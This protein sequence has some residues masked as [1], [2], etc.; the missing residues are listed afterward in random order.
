MKYKNK[1]LLLAVAVSA[2]CSHSIFAQ[3]GKQT[4][5][6]GSVI[7]FEPNSSG[8]L[9]DAAGIRSGLSE[10]G[11][12]FGLVY[13]SESATN[14]AGGYNHDNHLAYV[15]QVVFIFEQDLERYTGIPDAK[16]E[17]LITNRNHDNNLTTQRVQ[18]SRAYFN[19]LNQEVW[20]G[21]SITRLGYLSFSRSFDDRRL[22]WRVGQ[23]N[24]QQTFDQIA[25][26]D[27]QT[28]SLCGGKSS[29]ARS[30]DTW[31]IHTWG[32][33]FAY[34]VTPE[35]TL[36]TGVLE[37][38][39]LST[40]RGRTWSFSTH[41]SKGVLIPVEA[42]YKTQVNGLPGLYN[43]GVMYNNADQYEL[44]TAP[45]DET[46][47]HNN[48]WFMWAGFNQQITRSHDALNRGMSLA[49]GFALGDQ[50]TDPF[51]VAASLS[52]RY[53]GLFDALPNDWIGLGV[54]YLDMSKYQ[55]RAQRLQN[56]LNGISDYSDPGYTPVVGH[57]IQLDLYYR[58]RPVPW[59]DIQPD[60]QY[61]IHPGAIKETQDAVVVGLKTAVRF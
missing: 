26:C 38:N 10:K 6:D 55:A 37:K 2:L 46:R 34:D 61:W 52:A 39:N 49:G 30:W 24:Y 41:G 18:D 27:F 16:I 11:F 4:T 58:F 33:T 17:G 25:P 5:W 32:T 43:L 8:M 57:S 28:L 13:T 60:I 20:G 51:H 7:G 1:A 47:S 12:N 35:L 9:G 45:G 53:R 56:T 22:H 40:Q 29:Y 23:M 54:S 48:T 42:Q 50:R 31:N 21:G 36:K 3:D 19:D 14:V 44:Y 59:L 15:D